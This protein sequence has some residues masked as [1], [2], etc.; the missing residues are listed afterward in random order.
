MR[1][2]Q[3][4]GIGAATA[5]IDKGGITY[6]VTWRQLP[7]PVGKNVL[8][9]LARDERDDVRSELRPEFSQSALVILGV[10][11][12]N[13]RIA[14]QRGIHLLGA[15]LPDQNRSVIPAEVPGIVLVQNAALGVRRAG[16]QQQAVRYGTEARPNSIQDL[17]V[18]VGSL[19]GD[20]ER[21]LVTQDG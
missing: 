21:Q 6:A 11:L 2:R 19:A 5:G 10:H 13:Q 8:N 7:H 3:R 16:D 4:H 1:N 20:P 9:S 12:S 14:N 15:A 18:G 17:E